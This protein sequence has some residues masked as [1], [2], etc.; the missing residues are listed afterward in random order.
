M[1]SEVFN[2]THFK[3][4]INTIKELNLYIEKDDALGS[5]FC[6]GHSYFSNLSIEDCSTERLKRIVDY[7][8]IPM[9]K[10]YWFDNTDMVNKW[11]KDLRAI[12]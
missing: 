6:I 12:F 10:E 1:N 2:N 9:I 4:V 5:G 7:E 3:K 8:I 11:E